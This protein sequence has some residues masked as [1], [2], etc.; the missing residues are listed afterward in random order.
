MFYD[1]FR[2]LIENKC[3]I[4]IKLIENQERDIDLITDYVE[5]WKM[6]SSNISM[7]HF[8]FYKFDRLIEGY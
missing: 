7:I 8:N 3:Q 2:W 5:K 6:F 1:C 4:T